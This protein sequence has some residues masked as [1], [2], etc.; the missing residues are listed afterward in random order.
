LFK[1][2]KSYS[3]NSALGFLHRAAIAGMIF[4]IAYSV[5]IWASTSDVW[6][7]GG[8]FWSSWITMALVYLG[9]A[10]FLQMRHVPL[11]ESFVVSLTS[12]VSMIWLYEIFYH[13]SFWNSWNYGSTPFLFL[14]EN[15]IFINYGLIAATA[16]AGY[17]YMKHSIW[18]WVSFLVMACIWIFWITIGFPQ[19]EFPGKLYNFA[20][21]RL[22][23]DNP[24]AWALP[25]NV[26]TKL[27]L[28][29]TYILVYLPSKLEFSNA[30]KSVHRVL[31]E[32]GV[33]DGDITP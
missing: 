7:L 26:V 15:A 29:L 20:W 16:F 21:S 5:Y 10:V 18:L 17:R 22:V 24:D 9:V 19:F 11:S 32:R 8:F 12:L 14:K 30:K 25:L 23:I 33:L 28:G 1:H 13:F 3:L 4:I 31:V 27:L 6:G 2:L